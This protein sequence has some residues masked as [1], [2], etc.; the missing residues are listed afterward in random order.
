VSGLAKNTNITSLNLSANDLGRRTIEAINDVLHINKSLTDL[1][2][3]K[4][5]LSPKQLEQVGLLLA[6]KGNPEKVSELKNLKFQFN[7]SI[8]KD[9]DLVGE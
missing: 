7:Q 8:I 3:V 2:L 6:S 9:T 1:N 4:N 5:F